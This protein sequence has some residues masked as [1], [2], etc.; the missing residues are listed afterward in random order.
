MILNITLAVD[1]N[2]P[3]GAKFLTGGDAEVFIWNRQW[4]RHK[5]EAD[6]LEYDIMQAPHHCFWHSLSED[7][8]S[9]HREKARL[10][11][12][13][14]KRRFRRL[15]TVPSSLLVVSLLQTMTVI[16]PASVQSVSTSQSWVKQK[17]SFTA[18]A[19][20][21]AKNLLSL[22]CLPSLLRGAASLEERSWIEGRSRD[23]LCAYPHAARRIVMDRIAD[24]LHQLQRHRGLVRVGGAKCKR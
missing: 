16:L 4:Q 14:R 3:D 7:S 8:W 10:D 5:A 22:S 6:V 21:R 19:N 11:A 13:A 18:R 24:A 15:V 17:A 9:T 1:A 2:T 23:H 20:T 12:D